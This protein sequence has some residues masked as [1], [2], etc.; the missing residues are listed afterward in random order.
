MIAVILF[1]NFTEKQLKQLIR[2]DL[3]ASGEIPA[4]NFAIPLVMRLKVMK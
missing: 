3:I 2:L 4:L 1:S